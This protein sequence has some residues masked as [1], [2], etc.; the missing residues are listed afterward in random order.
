MVTCRERN[1]E[2]G[3][4][5][6]RREKNGSPGKDKNEKL[7][8]REGSE[9]GISGRK[10]TDEK[11]IGKKKGGRQEEGPWRRDEVTREKVMK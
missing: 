9:L 8:N 11:K 6:I 3:G 7:S 4:G 10:K 1:S 5:R 2:R